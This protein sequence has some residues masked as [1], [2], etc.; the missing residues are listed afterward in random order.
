MAARSLTLVIGNRNYSSWSLRPWALLH[1]LDI[2]F[3]ERVLKF[4]SDDWER[5]IESLSPTGLVPVLWEGEPGSGF[6]TFDTSAIVERIAELFPDRRVWP[7]NDRA[8]A[9]ARSLVANFHSGYPALRSAMPMNVRSRYPGCGLTREVEAE[10]SQLAR[11]WRAAQAE[12]GAGGPFLFGDFSAVD[13]FFLP[14]ASRFATYQPP[15]ASDTAAYCRVLL[16]T[17]AMRAWTEAARAEPEVVAEEEIYADC[18][19]AALGS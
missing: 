8:R 19:P 9:R 17:R 6:V 13:A 4:D 16:A 5:H 7:A 1:Q 14:V 3:S 2:P 12:F 18:D 10:I 15:L 11:L